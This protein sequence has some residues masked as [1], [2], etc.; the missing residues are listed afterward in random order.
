MNANLAALPPQTQAELLLEETV[1]DYETAGGRL[2]SQM[3]VAGP[4]NDEPAAGKLARFRAQ[5]P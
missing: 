2:L 5:L 3:E 1:S 4:I